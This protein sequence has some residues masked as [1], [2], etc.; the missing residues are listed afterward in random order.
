M[1]RL[2]PCVGEEERKEDLP[3]SG[4]CDGCACGG[5][6]RER[7][8]ERGRERETERERERLDVAVAAAVAACLLACLGHLSKLEEIKPR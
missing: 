4:G 7:D 1:P 6:G 3:G 2:P 5:L 8:G